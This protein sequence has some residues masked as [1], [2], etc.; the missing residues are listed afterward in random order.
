M[1]A[2]AKPQGLKTLLA[3]KSPN[4]SYLLPTPPVAGV[5]GVRIPRTCLHNLANFPPAW[6]AGWGSKCSKPL[7]SDEPWREREPSQWQQFTPSARR[8]IK[9]AQ[10]RYFGE[11]LKGKLH[12]QEMGPRLPFSELPESGCSGAQPFLGHPQKS[13]PHC[14]HP[15]IPQTRRKQSTRPGPGSEA[16]AGTGSPGSGSHEG[17]SVVQTR[18]Q[19]RA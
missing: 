11:S 12:R 9:E 5:W 16:P 2:R 8:K 4:P 19:V 18:L 14:M 17:K 6:P 15:K 10:Q 7:G 13:S 3:T 1:E